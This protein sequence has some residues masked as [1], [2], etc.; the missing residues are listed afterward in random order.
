[1]S[2]KIIAFGASSSRNS[3]NKQFASYTAQQ[4][5]DVSYEILDL[6]DYEMPLYSIDRER[7]NGVPKLASDFVAKL[8][9]ADGFIVSFAEHNG[10]FTVAYKNIMD[11]V[12]RIERNIWQQR[13]I[14]LLTTTPGARG[15]ISVL[16]IAKRLISYFNPNVVGTFSLPL[17]RKN[18]SIEMGITDPALASSYQAL[19][20]DFR[21]KI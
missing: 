10:N 16:S 15:G 12:S 5:E 14:I 11:W 18:F 19:L 20:Q 3:I 6:N 8:A 9:E 4:L 13:P 21:S 17:Y 1:M 2:K 7:A